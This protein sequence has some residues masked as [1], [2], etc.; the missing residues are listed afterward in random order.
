MLTLKK[1][2]K[3]LKKRISFKIEDKVLKEKFDKLKAD[4]KEKF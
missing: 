3:N 2:K 4:I 1:K